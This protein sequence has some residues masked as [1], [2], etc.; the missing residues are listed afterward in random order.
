MEEV[1]LPVNEHDVKVSCRIEFFGG[2]S[3]PIPSTY[4]D[5]NLDKRDYELL[6]E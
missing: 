3:A 1:I 5:Y 2:D 6:K 4:N